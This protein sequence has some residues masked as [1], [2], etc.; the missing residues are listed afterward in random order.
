MAVLTLSI[1]ISP[2]RSM[3]TCRAPSSTARRRPPAPSEIANGGCTNKAA[4]QDLE[5]HGTHVAT[6]IGGW[7][8]LNRHRRRYPGGDDH[9][10]ESLHHCRLLLCRLGGGRAPLCGRQASRRRQSQPVCR[11]VSLFLRQ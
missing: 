6:T 8:K 2:A 3:S 7:V 4:V 10:A 1:R 9:C 5:D 11:P